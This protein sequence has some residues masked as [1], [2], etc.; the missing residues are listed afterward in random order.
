MYRWC[1][2]VV[3]VTPGLAVAAGGQVA[4]RAPGVCPAP[5]LWLWALCSCCFFPWCQGVVSCFYL[6]ALRAVGAACVALF[7]P[8][9]CALGVSCCRRL[10]GALFVCSRSCVVD[11]RW[12]AGSPSW[13]VPFGASCCYTHSPYCVCN[14][15]I[16]YA[17]LTHASLCSNNDWKLR[18]AVEQQ[19]QCPRALLLLTSWPQH[20][21]HAAE[22]SGCRN[23]DWPTTFSITHLIL[24]SIAHSY[25]YS[26]IYKRCDSL[27]EQLQSPITASTAGPRM[28]PILHYWRRS[29]WKPTTSA[30]AERQP[31]SH[32]R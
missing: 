3:G 21:R 18:G 10:F 22:A 26:Y 5:P 28:L 15:P 25:S 7:P 27:S 24:R 13:T 31:I 29:A 11:P 19:L 16:A 8:L 30:T 17:C 1:C 32:S 9:L 20:T 23:G 2:S 12:W 6:V 14:T 4:F